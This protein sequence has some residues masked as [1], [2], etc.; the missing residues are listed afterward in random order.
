[1]VQ[2][3]RYKVQGI[4]YKEQGIFFSPLTLNLEPLTLLALRS[5]EGEEGNPEP[6]NS[7]IENPVSSIEHRTGSPGRGL[8]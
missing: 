7:S 6:L 1:M 8:N 3:A 5:P 4:G 2:G